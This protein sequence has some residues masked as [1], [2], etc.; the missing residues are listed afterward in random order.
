MSGVNAMGSK[1]N[2]VN[3]SQNIN[4]IAVW[5]THIVGAHSAVRKEVKISSATI[6]SAAV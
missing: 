6:G 5:T 3:E 4:M 2:N 1:A